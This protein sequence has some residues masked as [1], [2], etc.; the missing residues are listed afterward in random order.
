LKHGPISLIED[1][2]LVVAMATQEKLFEKTLSNIKE[3]K[4]RGAVVLSITEEENTQI[5]ECSDDV[6]Y[7]PKTNRMLISSLAAVVLQLFA[8]YVACLN[9][10]DIDQPRNLA[11]SV[12][13]E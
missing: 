4:S 6:F 11:K 10:N 1:G 8:Y 12:T 7:L 5:E 13:V 2:T 9:G 3:V